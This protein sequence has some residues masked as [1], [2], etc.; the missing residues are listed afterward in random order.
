MKKTTLVLSFIL[1]SSLAFAQSKDVYLQINHRVGSDTL[2]TSTVG[3]NDNGNDFTISRIQYYAD[4][5]LF[6]HDNGAV[7]T[8][9]VV[10]LVDG[11]QNTWINL[12]TFDIDS[13]EALRFAIGVNASLNHLD[14]TTYA[15]QHP[16]APKSPSMHWGWTS[17]YRFLC[18][19]GYAGSNFTQ[20]FQF[21]ALGDG[22]FAHL[23]IPTAGM[24]SGDS[25]IITITADYNQ[26]FKGL[27]L[28]TGPISHGETGDAAKAIHNMNNYVFTSQEG[29]VAMASQELDIEYQLYPN[30]SNGNVHVA[31]TAPAEFQIYNQAGQL[32][33][34][35]AFETGSNEIYNLKS[36]LYVLNINALGTAKSIR[37]VVQ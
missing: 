26:L 21:H 16:L 2:S 5:F 25:L 35:G 12:G 29:N 34:E 17:G 32:V 22:N 27:N 10:A 33:R 36:G 23:T 19:E 4:Q 15:Q 13:L 8:S 1:A 3:Q 30:P 18:A 6:V 37:F 20:N 9:S 31:L 11:L 24:V 28:S 14:P 7:D